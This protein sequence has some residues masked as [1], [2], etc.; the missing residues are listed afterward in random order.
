MNLSRGLLRA[1]PALLLF[2]SLAGSACPDAAGFVQEPAPAVPPGLVNA[3]FEETDGEG[4]LPTGWH[5][6]PQGLE[7][8]WSFSTQEADP[9]S[10]ARALRIDASQNRGSDGLF[11]NCSQSIDAAPW[12]GKR[13]RFRAAVRIAPSGSGGQAQLWF[14][15]DRQPGRGGQAATAFFDNMDDRPIRDTTW[16]HH[17]IVAEIAGDA[18]RIHLGMIVIGQ[19]TAWIDDTSLESVPA[20]TPTTGAGLSGNGEDPQQPFFVWWLVLPMA[21][22]VLL[23]AAF[24]AGGS[25]GRF[26]FRFTLVYWLLYALPR[27]VMSVV[28]DGGYQL[29]QRYQQVLVEPPVRWV[30]SRVLGIEKTLVLPGGSGDTTFNHVQLLICFGVALGTAAAWTVLAGIGARRQRKNPQRAGEPAAAGG[31]PE[32]KQPERPTCYPWLKD[33]LRSYLRY[34]LAFEML[35]YGLAKVISEGNQ[36]PLLAVEQ[37]NQTWGDSSPMHV[38][39]S[40]MGASRPYTVFA[41]LA[42]VAAGL[43]LVW[44]RTALAGAVVAMAVMANVVLLNFCYD[45]PV[46]QFSLHLLAMAFTIALPD[47]GRLWNVFV[48]NRP[49]AGATLRPPWAGGW[50]VWP[51]RMVQA[52]MI[53]VGVGLPVWGTLRSEWFSERGTEKIPPLIGSWQVLS[54]ERDG[55]PLRESDGGESLWERMTL[56][57]YSAAMTGGQGA[58]D[59]FLIRRVDATAASGSLRIAENGES[60]AFTPASGLIPET[61]QVA[62]GESGRLVLSGVLADGGQLQVRLQ[63]IDRGD[64]LLNRRGFRW[65]SERPYNR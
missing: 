41:G 17:E 34:V 63:R 21:A 54:M 36:F 3:G 47:A 46:K 7:S 19:L 25:L 61:M 6:S 15:V 4:R 60:I 59:V 35:G 52:W 8:R 40:F 49:A 58:K 42:E 5:C 62:D 9:A 50:K 30:A 31:S 44:R 29:A 32:L 38:L 23:A 1:L 43:L 2:F 24:L 64:F 37:L 65:I 26:A 10:G 48:R 53:V 22:L 57:R 11:G 39:W 56:I 14:R 51:A 55:H 18:A 13:V 16:Q 20:G 33:L 27:P 28:P 12:R 45:V